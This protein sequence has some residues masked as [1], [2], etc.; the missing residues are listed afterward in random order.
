[1]GTPGSPRP[2]RPRCSYPGSSARSS[3]TGQ[4]AARSSGGLFVRESRHQ[5]LILPQQGGRRYPRALI[6][7]PPR[8][9]HN[10]PPEYWRFLEN[11]GTDHGNR[12]AQQSTTATRPIMSNLRTEGRKWPPESL[13]RRQLYTCRSAAWTGS[14]TRGGG[15]LCSMC[16]AKSLLSTSG[17]AKP[18]IAR[19]QE[20]DHG[21][22]GSCARP[23]TISDPQSYPL[24]LSVS[25]NSCSISSAVLAFLRNLQKVSSRNW[26]EIFSNARS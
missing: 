26:R 8:D 11:R 10:Q 3:R 24:P 13:R 23:V 2:A 15:P 19:R 20:A 9:D 7:L 22:P 16:A 18:I 4:A 6:L 17:S 1:M 14:P 5:P 25:S 21:R 12:S